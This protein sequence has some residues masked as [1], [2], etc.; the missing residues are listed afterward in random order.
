MQL[1]S[2]LVNSI[3]QEINAE[4]ELDAR[5]WTLGPGK[6]IRAPLHLN[7]IE[8]LRGFMPETDPLWNRSQMRQ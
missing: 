1:A 5:Y 3:M 8:T 6:G 7:L 4:D 2:V